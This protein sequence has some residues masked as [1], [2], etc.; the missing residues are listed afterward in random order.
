M[1]VCG[2]RERAEAQRLKR[3]VRREQRGAV[4]ELRK[5]AAY[6]HGIREQ[7]AARDKAERSSKLRAGMSFMQQQASDMASGGQKG[8][9][10]RKKRK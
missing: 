6:L 10:K 1:L 3:E 5:D 8:M 9:W 2:R 4:R 7:E